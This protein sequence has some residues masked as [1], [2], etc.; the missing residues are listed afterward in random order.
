MQYFFGWSI[1]TN[2][3]SMDFNQEIMISVV[4]AYRIKR[5]SQGNSYN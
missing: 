4:C 2:V 3:F 1:D 5:L